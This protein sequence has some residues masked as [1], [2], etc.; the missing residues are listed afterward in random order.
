MFIFS[1][2]VNYSIKNVNSNNL[3]NRQF[4]FLEVLDNNIQIQIKKSYYFAFDNFSQ[5]QEN[6]LA[7][8][9]NTF[10]FNIS[11]TEIKQI[12][13][14]N[15]YDLKDENIYIIHSKT[16][17]Q[18]MQEFINGA[19]IIDE[20][21]QNLVIFKEQILDYK[22]MENQYEITTSFYQDSCKNL[23]KD[24][25]QLLYFRIYISKNKQSLIVPFSQ[26]FK[27][28]NDIKNEINLQELQIQFLILGVILIFMIILIF[29]FLIK[30][31]IL[32]DQKQA[33]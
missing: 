22:Q 4:Y 24:E 29:I 1:N 23:Q 25:K 33:L 31:K 18:L 11:F 28:T 14:L 3:F 17:I 12:K 13:G 21:N 7:Q 20:Q 30:I 9:Q 2:K 10:K 5:V 26:I 19:N 15:I 8:T 6:N 16:Q 27:Q 32:S